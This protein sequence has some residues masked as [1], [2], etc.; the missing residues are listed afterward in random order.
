M[1]Q[2]C[3]TINLTGKITLGYCQ[4]YLIIF[5]LTLL[6]PL[7]GLKAHHRLSPRFFPPLVR[8]DNPVPVKEDI[9]DPVDHIGPVFRS[10]DRARKSRALIA[11][12]AQAEE[13][14]CGLRGPD[15]CQIAHP[16][17]AVAG[18]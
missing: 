4:H 17:L 14:Q 16:H 18:A 15:F 11:F 10:M 8:R 12:W 1:T 6:P 5:G 13:L 9:C 2:Y 7:A 3:L